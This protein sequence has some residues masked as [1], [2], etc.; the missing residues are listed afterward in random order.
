MNGSKKY[1]WAGITIGAMVLVASALWAIFSRTIVSLCLLSFLAGL[2][3]IFFAGFYYRL[4]HCLRAVHDA[5]DKDAIEINATDKILGPLAEVINFRME[6]Y[7]QR[8]LKLQEQVDELRIQMQM[9]KKQRR[10][11]EAIIHSIH[12]AVLV[13]DDFDRMIVSNNKAASIFGFDIE[14]CQFELITDL[15]SQNNLTDLIRNCRSSQTRGVQHEV[16]L[17]ICEKVHTFK[18]VISAIYDEKNDICGFVTVL[19]DITRE[20]EIS[21]MKND[22][23]SH[24]S[25]ELKTPLASIT[26]YA[27][28][29]VDGEA[30][31]EET[32]QEFLEVIQSQAQRLNRLI[33]DILNVSRI[34]SGLVKVNKTEVSVAMIIKEAV[35]MI[36]SYAGEKNIT[37]D[38]Q[39]TILFDQVLGDRD[40]ISQVVINLLSN[41]VKYTPEGGH[42]TVRA[43]VDESDNNIK[44]TIA[45]TGVGIPMD[46]LPHVFDKFYRVSANN[47]CAKGTGLGLNLVKQIVE[48]VH[49]GKVF[50]ESVQ[51]KGSVFGFEL[52]LAKMPAG[53]TANA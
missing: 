29:L 24:V 14:K 40:M 43:N 21:R 27:E 44:V 15:I 8:R 9:F 3:F 48:K 46:D 31:D 12:D 42:I 5:F 50:V 28:M 17:D 45:D 49:G 22:F 47:K 53:A 30:N 20:R 36:R 38:D 25:H 35:D 13:T 11:T 39:A 2:S 32:K 4:R 18:C 6:E 52:E 1:V 37:V 41:A 23:V 19:H 34:E 51:G 16:Y 7:Q 33:E 10:N 26:A